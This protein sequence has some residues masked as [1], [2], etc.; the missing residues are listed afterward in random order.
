MAPGGLLRRLMP[1]RKR[2]EWQDISIQEFADPSHALMVN[3]S[4]DEASFITLQEHFP[5]LVVAGETSKQEGQTTAQRV[6]DVAGRDGTSGKFPLQNARVNLTEDFAR[7]VDEQ[8]VERQIGFDAM[9]LTAGYK[10][11]SASQIRLLRAHDIQ[12]DPAAIRWTLE[13][14]DLDQRPKYRA[15]SY[16]W[17]DANEWE[18]ITIDNQ[19]FVIRTRLYQFLKL[20]QSRYP[21][22]WIWIDQ[23]CINQSSIAERNHQV[24]LMRR[25]YRDAAEVIVWL[26]ED[27]TDERMRS[28]KVASFLRNHENSASD[29]SISANPSD[30]QQARGIVNKP[31]WTRIWIVQELLLARALVIWW[32]EEVIAWQHLPLRR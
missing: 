19:R 22:E 23:I 3:A 28:K 8:P 31:Y 27:L 24:S 32:D 7:N 15:L 30:R 11:L 17:G 12:L 10:A 5:R 4:L 9:D 16:T 13:V 29:D 14:F 20:F 18:Y 21:D 6:P 1:R 2:A 25:I 26:G